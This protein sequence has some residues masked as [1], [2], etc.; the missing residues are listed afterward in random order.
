MLLPIFHSYNSQLI[1][2]LLLLPKMK[3][4]KYN[5]FSVEKKLNLIIEEFNNFQLKSNKIFPRVDIKLQV[6]IPLLTNPPKQVQ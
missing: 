1:K 4:L 3:L 2:I 5:W 6:N